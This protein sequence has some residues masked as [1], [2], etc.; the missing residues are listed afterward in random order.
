MLILREMPLMTS[1]SLPVKTSVLQCHASYPG[2]TLARRAE[3][4]R[5]RDKLMAQAR[6]S[7]LSH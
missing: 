2:N 5:G 1:V 3:L 7:P 6:L 4:I